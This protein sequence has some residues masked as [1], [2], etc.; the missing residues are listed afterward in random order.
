MHAAKARTARAH[1]L[2]AVHRRP[3]PTAGGEEAVAS[4]K[5]SQ[6]ARLLRAALDG[7]AGS[8]WVL[9]WVS[10]IQVLVVSGT[11][12]ELTVVVMTGFTVK[13]PPEPRDVMTT[14]A[15]E[16]ISQRGKER[17]SPP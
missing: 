17:I 10:P 2:G 9:W 15:V 12:V 8:E 11:L 4:V 7:V 3:S 6:R 16:V 14:W 13:P 5:A 1:P